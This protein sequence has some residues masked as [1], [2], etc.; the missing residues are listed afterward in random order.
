MVLPSVRRSEERVEGTSD[1]SGVLQDE[2]LGVCILSY[3][4]G[5]RRRAFGDHIATCFTLALYPNSHLQGCPSPLPS[6]FLFLLSFSSFSL[7]LLP[8]P[9]PSPSPRFSTASHTSPLPSAPLFLRPPPSPDA[10]RRPQAPNA[11][12]RFKDATP[13]RGHSGLFQR[14]GPAAG[15]PGASLMTGG[16]GDDMMITFA[17]PEVRVAVAGIRYAR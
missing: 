15:R 10:S 17:T 12:R 13:H 1:L 3:L 8:R 6:P 7:S 14:T 4:I 11:R 2:G 5:R 16:R 9:P